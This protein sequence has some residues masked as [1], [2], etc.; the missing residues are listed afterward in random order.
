MNL[1]HPPVNQLQLRGRIIAPAQL[2]LNRHGLPRL[3]FRLEVRCDDRDL[4]PKK[5]AGV[6]YFSIVAFGS[7]FMRLQPQLFALL[8]SKATLRE[9]LYRVDVNENQLARLREGNEETASTLTRLI[10]WREL[11]KVVTRFMLSEEG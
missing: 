2:F 3:T 1:N 5:P 9:I 4:P 10:L 7:E 6:D 8:G 11:Q